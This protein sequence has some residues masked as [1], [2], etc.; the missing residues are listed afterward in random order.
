MESSDYVRIR[1]VAMGPLTRNRSEA[2]TARVLHKLPEC[3]R[4]SLKATLR[5]GLEYRRCDLNFLFCWKLLLVAFFLY[6][7]ITREK[8]WMNNEGN[9]F[10]LSASRFKFFSTFSFKYLCFLNSVINAFED[11]PFPNIRI[12]IRVRFS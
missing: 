8:I 10:I 2:M 6:G 5:Y 12:T 4:Y 3:G 7:V 11:I 1:G 9:M